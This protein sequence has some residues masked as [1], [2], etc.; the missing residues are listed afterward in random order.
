MKC[1]LRVIL[2]RLRSPE[3]GHDGVPDELFD[4]PA[5]SL[6]LLGHRLVEPFEPRT[7]A[8]W[9]LILCGGSRADQI[10][11]ENGGQFPLGVRGHG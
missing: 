6:D 8:L 2:E 11:E 9:I 1:P 10:G 5:G 3:S 4:R 7:R